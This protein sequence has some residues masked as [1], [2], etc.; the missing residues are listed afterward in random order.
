MINQC[1]GTYTITI[2][3][4][5]EATMANERALSDLIFEFPSTEPLAKDPKVSCELI[6]ELVGQYDIFFNW[7]T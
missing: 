2:S 3:S 5:A 1:S 7:C 4:Q 6:N